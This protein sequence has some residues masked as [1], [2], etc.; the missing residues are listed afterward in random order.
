MQRCLLDAVSFC[1][2]ADEAP[3]EFRVLQYSGLIGLKGFGFR[4]TGVGF[5][6]SGFR[7]LSF[8]A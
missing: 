2:K 6:A 3:P 1:H 8:R 5:R 7:V 4:G